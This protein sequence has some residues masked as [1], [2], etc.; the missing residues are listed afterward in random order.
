MSAEESDRWMSCARALLAPNIEFR[1]LEELGKFKLALA[2]GVG[3]LDEGGGVRAKL[4][5]RFEELLHGGIVLSGFV[6]ER[7][8]FVAEAPIF[9]AGKFGEMIFQAGA[10]LVETAE[11]AV[12]MGG[13]ADGFGVQRSAGNGA[14]GE[15]VGGGQIVRAIVNFAEHGE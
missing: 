6:E 9:R 7:G 12:E 14:A 4:F 3:L 11:A 1:F 8:E 2:D 15:S 5:L 10:R 13:E